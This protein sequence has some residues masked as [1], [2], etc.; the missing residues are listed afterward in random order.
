MTRAPLR[1]PRPDLVHLTLRQPP[2]PGDDVSSIR[3]QRDE[4]DELVALFLRPDLG[5]VAN[6]DGGFSYCPH[7]R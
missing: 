1:L 6:E 4:V 3:M 2:D 5:R 7:L